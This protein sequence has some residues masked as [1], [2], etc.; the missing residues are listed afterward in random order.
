MSL[1][2]DVQLG[3]GAFQLDA[4]FNAGAGT[5]VLY[6]RSG[7]GKTSVINAISGLQTP[8]IGRI[9]LGEDVLFDS[10][11]GINVPVHKRRI[12]YVFQDARLFPHLTVAQNLDFSTRFCA[13]T[14]MAK[15]RSALIDML[16]IGGLLQRHPA[17]LSGGEKQRVAL[18]RALLSSPRLLLLDEP[19]AALDETRKQEI[20]PY[21]E[22]L[23]AQGG[24]PM[25]YVTHDMSEI[26]RLADTLVVLRDGSCVVQGLAEDVLADPRNVKLIG[27]QDAGALLRGV[28]DHHAE[29]GLSAIRLSAGMLHVPRMDLP[30]DQQVRLKIRAQD[31]ILSNTPPSGLSSQNTLAVQITD[32][33]RGEGPSVA[34]ALRSGSDRLLARI[35]VRALHEMQLETGQKI[36]AI[37][38]SNAVPPTAIALSTKASS[39]AL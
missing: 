23:R 11:T 2:V 29:D 25:I 9:T 3:L 12:G 33:H 16:G 5:T 1:R 7:S 38:K 39:D 17:A 37:L 36:W 13:I 27:V 14:V 30:I 28:V 32:I 8:D 18:G 20:M 21:F 31:V 4:K 10:E 6:G 24:P 26:V 34:I 22:R 15:E 35:T 19:L